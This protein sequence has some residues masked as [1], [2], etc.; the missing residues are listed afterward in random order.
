[1]GAGY[2]LE[3]A[4]EGEVTTSSAVQALAVMVV[5]IFLLL[6]EPGSWP[7]LRQIHWIT[8]GLQGLRNLGHCWLCQSGPE[9]AELGLGLGVG[10]DSSSHCRLQGIE[11]WL[12]VLLSRGSTGNGTQQMAFVVQAGQNDDVACQR[13]WQVMGEKGFTKFMRQAVDK[14]IDLGLFTVVEVCH[15]TLKVCVVDHTLEVYL[16]QTIKFLLCC[17]L[18]VRVA[19]QGFK[20]GNELVDL[21]TW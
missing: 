10:D 5:A 3:R 18:A 20:K 21:I 14:G 1:M 13:C 8:V 15:D 4:D 6:R 7:A 17:C 2:R 19:V 16:A 9:Q 12:L 11:G